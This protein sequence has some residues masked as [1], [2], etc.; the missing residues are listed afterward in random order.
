MIANLKLYHPL[1]FNMKINVKYISRDFFDKRLRNWIFSF[2]RYKY[3]KGFSIR[4]FGL[5]LNVREKG[6]IEKLKQQIK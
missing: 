4:M 1:I 3:M 2:K 5:H 6:G